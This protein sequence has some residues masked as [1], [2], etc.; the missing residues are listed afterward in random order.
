M[1]SSDLLGH[2]GAGR[3]M[4]IDGSVDEILLQLS[5]ALSTSSFDMISYLSGE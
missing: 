5:K 2:Q 1:K 3:R 4:E